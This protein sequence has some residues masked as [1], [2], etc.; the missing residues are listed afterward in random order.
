[1][2]YLT[3]D[4]TSNKHVM[5]YPHYDLNQK[6]PCCVETLTIDPSHTSVCDGISRVSPSHCR[7]IPLTSAESPTQPLLGTGLAEP[8]QSRGSLLPGAAF[9]IQLSVHCT[10]I[11]RTIINLSHAQ[12]LFS[13]RH[14]HA[15]NRTQRWIRHPSDLLQCQP[16]SFNTCMLLNIGRSMASYRMKQP[17]PR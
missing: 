15:S 16:P 17:P 12:K 5:F 1:M 11:A 2:A 6:P 14:M 8:S 7:V 3:K 10:V 4:T 13:C 9:Q